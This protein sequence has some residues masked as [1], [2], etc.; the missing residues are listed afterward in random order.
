MNG[1]NYISIKELS[2]LAAGDY[3]IQFISDK[4][5]VTKKITK[6]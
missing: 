3:F 4:Q 6:Q 2:N 5:I 1:L